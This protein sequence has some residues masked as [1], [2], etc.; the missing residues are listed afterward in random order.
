MNARRILLLASL[1]G[2]VTVGL[3]AF[4]A[5][6]L[7]GVLGER[8]G[9]WETA[10]LYQMFHT[11]AL[12]ALGILMKLEYCA[13]AWLQ[14]SAVAFCLGILLFS[15]SLYV[16]ALTGISWLGMIT[17]LGG[18]AFLSGWLSLGLA[19]RREIQ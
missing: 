12:L 19:L 13:S 14:R 4:G 1:S 9:T 17:P 16:L 7:A 15:G 2:F 10:V 5:H 3:G 6:G 18:L 8:I 11:S